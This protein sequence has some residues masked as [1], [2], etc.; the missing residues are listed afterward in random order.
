MHN[1]WKTI[2]L[3]AVTVAACGGGNGTPPAQSVFSTLGV[4][5]T[6]L[7]LVDG[8]QVQL[9]ATPRDQNGAQMTGLPQ[10]TFTVTTGAAASVT[11]SGLVTALAQGSSTVTASL[12]ASGVTRTATTNVNVTA[13][14]S[15]RTVTAS[16]TGQ[17][18]DP[19]T[20]KIANGGTVTWSF[21]GQAHNVVWDGAAPP[22]GNIP[23]RSNGD[24]ESRTFPTDGA[25]AYHC[26]IHGPS[27]DGRVIVRTP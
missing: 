17:T 13:L 15:D 22:G 8:D 25:Y 5:A 16:G 20:V 11:T 19:D 3:V 2:P 14:Q 12:T 10:P 4:S 24:L 23:A 7:N 26:S 27:M 9:V 18:F 1:V 6:T 21:P